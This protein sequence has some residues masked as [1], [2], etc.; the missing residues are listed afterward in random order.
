MR[1]MYP[2]LW[3]LPGCE[4][5]AVSGN[6]YIREQK[7]GKAL[8]HRGDSAISGD[9]RSFLPVHAGGSGRRLSNASAGWPMHSISVGLPA[10][11]IN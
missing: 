11:S 1:F 10:L 7:N 9:G 5:S 8:Y 3:N 6:D 4:K 2:P